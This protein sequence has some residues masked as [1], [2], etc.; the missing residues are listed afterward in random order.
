M[1]R[2]QKLP[3]QLFLFSILTLI[4]AAT[5]LAFDTY[6]AWN[7]RDIPEVLQE[8]IEPLNPQLD[9]KVLE[10]LSNRIKIEK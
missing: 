7:K 4:T 5:W 10:N 6:R 9:L 8:Q 1:P 2:K 3:R